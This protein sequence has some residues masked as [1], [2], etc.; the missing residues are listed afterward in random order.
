MN[1]F[2]INGGRYGLNE[3][4]LD[5]V[6]NNAILLNQSPPQNC[7]YAPPVEAVG[8]FK[9]MTS[10]YD[11]QYGRTGGGVISV[12]LK[13]G[14]NT[15]HGAL[16]EYLRRPWLEANTFANN[17]SAQPKAQRRSDQYGME[18]DGPVIFSKLYRGKDRTFFMFSYEHYAE[19][20]PQPVVGSV[21]TVL[22][23]QGDFSQTFSASGARYI[24]YDAL[25][26]EPNPAFNPSRPVALSNLQYIRQPFAGNIVPQNRMNGI[27][28][29]V[30]KD[31]PLPNQPGAAPSGLNNWFANAFTENSYPSYV[32]RLDHNLSSRVRSYARWY[33]SFRDGTRTD[34]WAWGTPARSFGAMYYQMDGAVFDTVASVGPTMVLDVRLG[35]NRF[36]VNGRYPKIDLTS[37]GFPASLVQQLQIPDLYP[38]FVFTNYLK[39]SS[40]PTTLTASET[41]SIQG[42]LLK[43]INR[44]S[45][46]LGGEVRLTHMGSAVRTNAS[47]IYNFDTGWT[48]S[49]PQVTDPLGGNAI[50]S[51][52]L[53]YIGSGS[54]NINAAP[55]ITW[56]IPS[57]FVHDDWQVNRKLTLNLGLRWDYESPPIERHNRQ[58]RGF[59]YSA[60]APFQV[61][62][63]NVK[64][65]LLFAGVNGQARGAFDRDLRNW[66]SR[67]GLA[68]RPT[69]KLPLVFRGGLGR[70]FLPTTEYGGTLGF[71]QTTTVQTSTTDFKPFKNLSNPFPNGLTPPTGATLGLATGAGDAISFGDPT[72]V[73]PAVWQFSAGFQY[74]LTPGL[75]IDASYV[76]SR[77]SRVQVAQSLNYLTVD[78]LA[79]GTAYLNQAVPNPFY[80]I[81]PSTTALGTQTAIQRRSLLMAYPQFPSVTANYRSLGRQWYN[82][83]QLK[84][85][86]TFK[87]GLS[88]LASY[89]FSKT[90]EA[91]AYSTS[92]SRRD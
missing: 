92:H 8:E 24:I 35:F 6:P 69:F 19:K 26:T 10:T 56:L 28:M 5:G 37:L 82:S 30:L 13:S 4:Q 91:T 12:Q 32:A 49:N 47:G 58:N 38:Q 87:S 86:R 71:S 77:T 34:T 22:Q 50:A 59:D 1:V 15:F 53:G 52:L 60:A 7:G 3:F 83:L 66:Q 70:Y 85:Q 80:G 65:G 90:M 78:Q 16:Y 36:L 57:V 61:P 40:N 42:S 46:K 68:Y 39:T 41:Y 14:T 67:A 79:L 25:T 21:A 44:H 31:I 73:I 23:R 81:L 75:I 88:F 76:G 20:L 45:V 17:A 89:T 55:Y 84:S 63:Y 62:G 2:S 43:V 54:A 64:G 74:E 27:A 18:V 48:S 11:A 29:R 72:R 9:I 51:F 33:H